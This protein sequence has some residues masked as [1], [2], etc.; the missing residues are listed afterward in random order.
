MIAADHSASRVRRPAILIGLARRAIELELG[1]DVEPALEP[2]VMVP[3]LER[4]AAT[5]VTLESDGRL[6]GC[7]G[8]LK[9]RR[10]L[11]DDVIGNARAAAFEDSRFPSLRAEELGGLGVEV[12]VL[13]E[14]APLTCD[15]EAELLAA[16][17]PGVDGLVLECGSH[18]STFLPQVWESLSDP[19][20]FLAALK[21]KAGLERD[22]WSDEMRFSRYAVE[23]YKESD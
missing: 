1:R 12:S 22:F 18:R 17:R 6:R 7:V 19:A 11:R 9:A 2:A 5:F 3:W 23:K 16:L 8:S 14:P 4:L 20:D 10:S 13:S 15:S 21:Q